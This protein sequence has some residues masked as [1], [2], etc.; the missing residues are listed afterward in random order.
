MPRH[1]PG[2]DDNP[3]P[4]MVVGHASMP[5]GMLTF[6]GVADRADSRSKELQTKT[7]VY[8]VD[9]GTGAFAAARGDMEAATVPG[10]DRRTLSFTI[11]CGG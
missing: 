11:D 6:T 10:E 2:L 7:F 9:G 5:E 1:K 4:F 8:A 3:H